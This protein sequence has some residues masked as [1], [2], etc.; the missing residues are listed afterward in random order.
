MKLK[1][2]MQDLEKMNLF[3]KLTRCN[4]VDFLENDELF[5]IVDK[6]QYGLAVGKNGATIKHVEDVFKKPIRLFE[7]SDD[8]KEF[9]QNMIPEAENIRVH[10]KT[11]IFEVKTK[12]R[13]KVIGRGGRNIDIVKKFLQRRFGIEDAKVK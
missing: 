10:D 5:F 13:A 2:S 8:L 11:V 3:S 6:G 1:L 9:A 4:V 12:D 7:S